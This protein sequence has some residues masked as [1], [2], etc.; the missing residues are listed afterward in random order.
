MKERGIM[1]IELPDARQLSDPV[2]EALRLRALR[3]CE[4]GFNETQLADL[5]G[6]RRERSAAG[7]LLTKRAAW[8]RFRKTEPDGL[9][10]RDEHSTRRRPPLSKPSSRIITP[11]IG[12]L[13]RRFGR[14]VPFA[15]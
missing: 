13:A 4:L 7:G 15:T 9:W 3:G 2:L 5:L 11:T 6:L 1:A 10:V 8:T 12:A 14:G